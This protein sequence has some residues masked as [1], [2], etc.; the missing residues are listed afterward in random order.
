VL[1]PAR[2]GSQPERFQL[3]VPESDDCTDDLQAIAVKSDAN[4]V[5]VAMK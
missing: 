2:P 5:T 1:S 4:Q 3:R